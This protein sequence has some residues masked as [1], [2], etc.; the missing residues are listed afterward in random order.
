MAAEVDEHVESFHTRPLDAGPLTFV[1]ADAL[2]LKVRERGRVAT[3][4]A[5]FGRSAPT[6]PCHQRRPQVAT[7]TSLC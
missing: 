3:A 4:I 5:V 6:P 1:V 7:T 2:V